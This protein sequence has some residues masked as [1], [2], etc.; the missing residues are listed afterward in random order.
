[1]TFGDFNGTNPR[2]GILNALSTGITAS[3]GNDQLEDVAG[4]RRRATCQLVWTT[5]ASLTGCSPPTRRPG[6]TSLLAPRIRTTWCYPSL[7]R[8]AGYL[9]AAVVWFLFRAERPA[10]RT[11]TNETGVILLALLIAYILHSLVS[12]DLD[13]AGRTLLPCGVAI[14]RAWSAATGSETK[15]SGVTGRAGPLMPNVSAI[16]SKPSLREASRPESSSTET[17]EGLATRADPRR[18]G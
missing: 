6:P 7:S 13:E 16:C 9:G 3:S 17:P 12:T 2:V 14:V 18:N 4:D 8:A 5:E 15:Q 10:L 11:A 1:M